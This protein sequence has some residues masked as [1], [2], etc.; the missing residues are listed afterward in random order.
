MATPFNPNAISEM[1]FTPLDLVNVTVERV[2]TKLYPKIT[3][4]MQI[5]ARAHA[6]QINKTTLFNLPTDFK[7]VIDAFRAQLNATLTMEGIVS[8]WKRFFTDCWYNFHHLT[9]MS[10]H[11]SEGTV[12]NDT[13]TAT[14]AQIL[15]PMKNGVVA[16]CRQQDIKFIWVQCVIDFAP[17]ITA[18]PYPTGTVLCRVYYIE[19]P[20]GTRAM[21][22]GNGEA[23]TLASYLGPANLRTLTPP[24]VK[25]QILDI[26]LQD[27]PIL[28]QASNFNLATANTDANA[29]A[30]DSKRKILKIAWHQICTSIFNVICPEY[31]NQPQA[32][33]EHIKQSYQDGDGNIVCTPVFAYYQR[34]MNAMQPFARDERFPVSVCNNLIDGIN[35]RLVPIFR[36]HYQAYA[37]IHDLQASYQQLLFPLILS[38]MK[39]AEDKVQSITTIAC[40]SIGGQAFTYSANVYP[41]QAESTLSRYSSGY[42]SDGSSGYCT[43]N[44]N[45]LWGLGKSDCCFGCKGVHPWM[46]DGVIVCPNCDQPGIRAIAEAAYKAWLAKARKRHATHASRKRN[47]GGTNYNNMTPKNKAKIKEQVL[48]SMGVTTIWQGD[49]ASTIT[50]DSA[51][52]GGTKNPTKPLILIADVQVLSLA[53]LSKDILPAPIVSNLLHILL[54][55]GTS[56]DDSDCP[57]VRCLVDTGA[58]LTTGI[59]HCTAAI[60]KRFPHCIAKVYGPDNYNAIVLSGIIQCGAGDFV[61]T[62][63]TMGFQFHLPYLTCEGQATSILIATGP[64]VAVNAIVGLPFIQATKMIINAS[65]HVVD[66]RALDTPSFPLEYRHAAVHVPILE[67]DSAARVNMSYAHTTLIKE[68][69][70]LELFFSN[71]A[72]IQYGA[73]CVSFGSWVVSQPLSPSK[74]ALRIDTVLGKHGLMESSTDDYSDPSW[75]I[76]PDNE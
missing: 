23:Y 71:A 3:L 63:L 38:T 57:S 32:A 17:L 19:L 74:S 27:G 43:N 39:L 28:L 13:T 65:D 41:S 40:S 25:V 69:K 59:F 34:M 7:L 50:N 52:S 33:L 42:K 12:M 58:A 22:N 29:F 24:E 56:L 26:C 67:E 76:Q 45:G 47:R 64:H 73:G 14:N 35:Q 72:V 53:N 44:T 11:N 61:A 55:F 62:K 66:M 70:N 37:V 15:L 9:I 31:S 16:A 36:R 10:F 4:T 18:L 75:G 30:I 51:K 20:Q 1:G 54:K 48:A 6:W 2:S 60:A 8:N 21:T 5:F 68:I 49:D 46:K